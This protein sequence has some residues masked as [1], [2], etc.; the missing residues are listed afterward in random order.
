LT[1]T[2]PGLYAGVPVDFVFFRWVFELDN[3]GFNMK[4]RT[5]LKG[6]IRTV[7]LGAFGVP[8]RT[9]C[10]GV[11]KSDFPASEEAAEGIDEEIA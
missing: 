10:S 4:R 5:F 7:L 11:K 8:L 2:G 6:S 1:G 3:V 9:V